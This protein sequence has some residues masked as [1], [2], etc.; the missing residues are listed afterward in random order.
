M[1]SVLLKRREFITLLG[2]AATWPLA[3]HAQQA[4]Q[5]FKIAV[6]TANKREAPQNVALLEEM[7]REGVIE[8]QNLVVR[9][10]GL[11]SEEVPE[12]AIMS[13]KEEGG[14]LAYGPR[15]VQIFRQLGRQLAK[16]LRGASPADLPVEQPTSFELVINLHAARA[17]GHEIPAGLVLRADKVVE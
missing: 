1:H 8:G 6:L 12:F 5:T 16:V 15:I 14:L 7:R 11:R 3:A 4:R 9:G 13:V 17:I 2:G 10:F